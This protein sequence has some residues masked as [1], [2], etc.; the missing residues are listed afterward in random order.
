LTASRQIGI[1]H[2][3]VLGFF[4]GA[5]AAC[6][7]KGELEPPPVV[8]QS[9]AGP[10][11]ATPRPAPGTRAAAAAAVDKSMGDA[12]S[13]KVSSEQ[14]SV[15]RVVQ[16]GMTPKLPPKEWEKMKSPTA[17]AQS[18]AP[19]SGEAKARP[20]PETDKPFILDGLL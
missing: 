7:V 10:G 9:E 1:R 13:K 15:N 16:P 20:R 11:D 18:K 3:I 12:P 5:L 14:S 2:W 19:A 4:A 8:R 6:G 17:A